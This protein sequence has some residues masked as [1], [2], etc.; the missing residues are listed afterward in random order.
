MTTNYP[1]ALDALTNPSGSDSLSSP[2]H[3]SQHANANDAIEAIQQKL[4]LTGS[5]SPSGVVSAPTGSFYSDS[6]NGLLYYKASGAG[7]SGWLAVATL[8]VIYST[9][10]T[11]N[12]QTASYTLVLADA[13]KMVEMNVGS[14]NNL[15]VPTDA[16]VAFPVG[17]RVDITQYGAG[18]TTVVASGGVTIR[19][20]PGLKMRAQY[21]GATLVK[22]A[23]DEWY[24]YGDI[25]A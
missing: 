9:P 1:A 13:G 5:G 6:T 12:T 25:S 4:G 23:T 22:R 17:T 19:A 18:Q 15:T 21:S 24:L 8:S 3:S 16:S 20:T 14:A 2:S 7:N 11:V 10:Q